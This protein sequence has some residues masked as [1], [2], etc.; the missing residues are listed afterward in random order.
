MV[1]GR[2]GVV[3]S[4]RFGYGGR[5][6]GVGEP[7]VSPPPAHQATENRATGIARQGGDCRPGTSSHD[8]QAAQDEDRPS[9]HPTGSRRET[10]RHLS[11]LPDEDVG[12]SGADRPN[13]TVPAV[14]GAVRRR[15]RPRRRRTGSCRPIRCSRS[16]SQ[17]DGSTQSLSLLRLRPG[18]FWLPLCTPPI[19]CAHRNGANRT[20]SIH[21]ASLPGSSCRVA[22]QVPEF[23]TGFDRCPAG[24]TRQA[25]KSICL[26][27][28]GLRPVADAILRRGIL[29]AIKA[30]IPDAT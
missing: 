19:F 22:R 20:P 21:R 17:A 8:P 24:P 11:R 2:I 16:P 27:G 23:R 26:R 14:P 29:N 6:T 13:P 12:R 18:H 5:S 10:V 9:L 28:I 7:T 3:Y 30:R 4:F 15:R 25:E 1:P